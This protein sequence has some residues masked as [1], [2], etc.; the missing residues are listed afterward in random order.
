MSREIAAASGLVV[1]ATGQPDNVHQGFWYDDGPAP[2][3][4]SDHTDR[5]A[6]YAVHLGRV[7]P[8]R[9]HECL[10]REARGWAATERGDLTVAL[11]ALDGWSASSAERALGGA[12]VARLGEAAA[13]RRAVDQSDLVLPVLRA[14]ARHGPGRLMEVAAKLGAHA[15][16]MDDAVEM[17]LAFAPGAEVAR[18]LA[19]GAVAA[20]VH[21]WDDD[22]LEHESLA[23]L[24]VQAAFVEVRSLLE[25]CDAIEPAWARVAANGCADCR[26]AAVLSL[27][28]AAEMAYARARDPDAVL[29][30]LRERRRSRLAHRVALRL[31][32][33]FTLPAS[34]RASSVQRGKPDSAPWSLGWLEEAPEPSLVAVRELRRMLERR[35]D[36]AREPD[37][38]AALA[39]HLP[40]P[41]HPADLP[42][43]APP[44]EALGA[45]H[46]YLEGL[47]PLLQRW[48]EPRVAPTA[49]K[50]GPWELHHHRRTMTVWRR[51][52]ERAAQRSSEESRA[53]V[54]WLG[55]LGDVPAL[56]RLDRRMGGTAA[57][58]SEALG[59]ARAVAAQV[60]GGPMVASPTSAGAVDPDPALR[61][62][63]L[64]GIRA[65]LAGDAAD[66]LE[67]ALELLWL[68]D[69]PEHGWMLLEAALAAGLPAGAI[70]GFVCR[71]LR[72]RGGA[73][74]ALAPPD[75]LVEAWQVPALRDDLVAALVL[76]PDPWGPLWHRIEQAARSAS[77]PRCVA[78]LF[79]RWV[80]A[81]VGVDRVRLLSSSGLPLVRRAMSAIRRTGGATSW[82][83]A[84]R[85]LPDHLSAAMALADLESAWRAGGGP[86][87]TAPAAEA[88]AAA[89]GAMT[90]VEP[91][92]AT[93]KLWLD[94]A[95]A[96]ASAPDVKRPTKE[97]APAIEAAPMDA[98]L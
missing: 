79:E 84:Y 9:A 6:A 91:V 31:A 41:P 78:G 88:I 30:C 24:P 7:A 27:A 28:T 3:L 68:V 40:R 19:R 23:A 83:K 64:S 77:P 90:W 46:L 98:G 74:I 13:L 35:P 80:D 96:R 47:E 48:C 52:L 85:A 1:G 15:S 36:L 5:V 53:A 62:P 42:T 26:D 21:P 93:S 60:A 2:M 65:A 58:V 12:V 97:N 45:L 11:D 69:P 25:I 16:R 20:M 59:R 72:E 86:G 54:E 81:G 34:R 29:R 76:A 61:R 22:G 95:V 89:A 4:E 33:R 38:L 32:A 94:A 49:W 71:L 63:A 87:L 10:Q 56:E 66:E 73:W 8:P 75:L 39:R 44:F 17:L 14:A 92:H 70:E 18:S 50:P 43:A 82:T 55:A 51:R 37:A 57:K 67:S